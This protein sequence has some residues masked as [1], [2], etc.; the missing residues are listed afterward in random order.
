MADL[1][2]LD[3]VFSETIARHFPNARIEDGVVELGFGDL[4][5]RCEV[6]GSQEF[7]G[8]RTVSL[9]MRLWGGAAG[10]AP[11]FISISGYGD[12][13]H[14]AVITGGCNWACTFG[15]LLRAGLAGEQ[16][17]DLPVTHATVQGH[18][19]AV[20]TDGL[21]R[22]VGEDAPP[23]GVGP[24]MS[25][26]RA[27]LGGRPWLSD[28]LLQSEALPVLDPH[29]PTILSVFVFEQA[30]RRIVEVKVNGCDWPHGGRALA[31]TPGYQGP[32]AVLLR[33]LT[34]VTPLH[35]EAPTQPLARDLLARTLAGLA[36]PLERGPRAAARWPGWAA[37]GGALLPP[38]TPEALAEVEADTGRL[39]GDY[40]AFLTE[41]A[42]GGAGPGYGLLAPTE[43]RTRAAVEGVP[44]LTD[45]AELEGD[46]EGVL[47][48]ADAGCGV[49]WQLVLR[50]PARGEVWA[51]ATGSDERYHRAAPSFSAWYRA[52]LDAAIRDV[53][54]WIHWNAAA[55]ATASLLS[56]YLE[57]L[58]QDGLQGDARF[59]A[60][61]AGLRP[62]A[63]R[64]TSGGHRFIEAGAGVPPCQGC[65]TLV[66]SFG[67][68]ADAFAI[69]T[70]ADEPTPVDAEAPSPPPAAP[71]RSWWS[72]LL[73]G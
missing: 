66:E 56:N 70:A 41:V 6:N 9:Y 5:M 4:K 53:A 3:L 54:P 34:V 43:A 16:V 27:T 65:V 35:P 33:E 12:N 55:C 14:N 69:P 57:R 45:G 19:M 28:R 59:E 39:P 26:V 62:G 44:S 49:T 29:R 2:P 23:G 61:Q 73:G 71:R 17:P 15:P 36:A 48:L 50:G 51:S 24:L 68:G 31:D 58:E 72:R 1:S 38:L 13:D 10:P 18:A 21:D 46:P 25:R 67:L 63:I 11:T 8:G 40:R 60:M 20:Y 52:W 64:L 30:E 42:A 7:G 22:F 47:L 32:G 37:H